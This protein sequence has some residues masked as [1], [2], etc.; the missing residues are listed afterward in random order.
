MPVAAKKSS[1]PPR[2]SASRKKAAPGGERGP[3]KLNLKEEEAKLLQLSAEERVSW[4]LKTFRRR[5]ILSSSFGAQSAVCLHMVTRQRP[6]I[7]VVL[8]DT[9]YLFPETYRFIDELTS[10]LEL[11]LKVFRP[12]WSA[13]WQEARHG[14][15]WE[16]GVR[17]IE[18]YNRLNKVEPLRR[19]L[20]QLGAKA[21]IAGI[22]RDQS[23][24]RES[25]SVLALQD[26]IV[27]V[28]PVFD[29]SDRDIYNYLTAHDLP[30]HPL[31]D[32]GYISI[33]DW[34]TSHK[35]SD[36]ESKDH[37]RFMGLKR[38]CGLHENTQDVPDGADF[39][40]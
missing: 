16:Q 27:K 40:I 38:E 7:P 15:L 36:V 13:A 29:W 10:R 32:E 20:K 37:V 34:H 23:S 35:L 18:D 22:R 2:K 9:G 12:E 31:W 17:G 39:E 25:I 5:I 30:Y 26:G 6:N 24:S 33:G 19:A 1:S 28:H 14:K 4:G 21:W 11:N 8:V 3:R